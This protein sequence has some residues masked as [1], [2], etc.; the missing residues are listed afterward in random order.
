MSFLHR[1]AILL[2]WF[3]FAAMTSAA[4]TPSASEP[5]AVPKLNLPGITSSIKTVYVIPHAHLDIGFVDVP[6]AVAANYKTMIDNQINYAQSRADYKFNIEESW[7]LDQWF[8]RTSDTTKR[9]QLLALVAAGRVEVGGGHS[10]LHSGKASH[11]AMPRFLWNA[12]RFRNQYSIP[13][14]TVFHDD[15]PGVAW[16]YPQILAKSGIKYLIC[17]ENLFIG[18]GFTQPWASYPFYWQ[19]P[20]G[21]RV[22]AWSA[23]KSYTEAFDDTVGY[24]VPFWSA[25]SIN[26]TRLASALSD[27]TSAGYPYDAVM[28]QYAFDDAFSTNLYSAIRT[29]NATYDNPKLVM[30]TPKD[31]FSY[32]EAKYSAQIEVRQGNWTTL[33]DTGQ[34]VEP[35]GDKVAKNAQDLLPVAEKMWAYAAILGLGSYPFAQFNPAWDLVMTLDEHSGAGGCWDG[36]WTQAQVDQNNQEFRNFTLGVQTATSATLAT[37]IQTLLGA[38]GSPS[39]DA[40]VVFNP[41]SWVRSDVVR[42]P[43]T[44]AR[45]AQQFKLTDGVTG[46]EVAYQKDAA[47]SQIVFVAPEVPSLGYKRFLISAGEPASPQTSLVLGANTVE[48]SRYRVTV[49]AHGHIS[50][51]LD[52]SAGREVVKPGAP[53]QFNRAVT[54]TNSEH[55]FGTSNAV[56]DAASTVISAGKTGPVAASLRVANAAHPIAGV[57]IT[58]YE[59]C[60]RIDIMDTPDRSQMPLA[61]YDMNSRYYGTAFPFNLSA[62]TGRIDTSAGWLNPATD[63]IPGS[64]IGSH[65]PQ[66]C[67][68]LS[69]SAYGVTFATPDVFAFSFGGLQTTGFSP[70]TPST[71]YSKF[72]RYGDECKLKGGEHWDGECGARRAGALGSAVC[73]ASPCEGV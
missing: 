71:L 30:A 60:D 48:N 53:V 68:D 6:S 23:R 32:F 64:Y 3:V 14:Q 46:A 20:D 40:V 63:T 57:E 54:A 29:W 35:Q 25:G 15:V 4:Q 67:I 21:S 69:E 61:P 22:L 49:D 16:T 38:A 28:V 7:T 51:I 31:F 59:G 73:A 52:K 50:S 5:D 13:I 2:T 70:S 43:V 42:V 10:T 9:N 65:T 39:Q 45:L 62:C 19:G 37:G 24:G 18:G 34:E 47:A 33:W 11:E 36:Y 12:A 17:G 27:L 58:L 66:H 1:I 56:P 72:L 26:Q 55:F 8:L 41:M 44:A